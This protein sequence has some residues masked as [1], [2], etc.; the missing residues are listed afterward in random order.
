M[1]RAPGLAHARGHRLGVR[2]AELDPDR[3]L[4]RGEL[5]LGR[6]LFRP[7]APR[8]P[9]CGNKKAAHDER[10]FELMLLDINFPAVPL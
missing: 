3:M 5:K 4:L 7:N 1:S 8:H 6:A 9:R 2:P 10:L